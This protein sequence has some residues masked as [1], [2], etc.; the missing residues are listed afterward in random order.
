MVFADVLQDISTKKYHDNRSE[1]RKNIM[2][3]V[4]NTGTEIIDTFCQPDFII[5]LLLLEILKVDI[6]QNT[7]F[8]YGWFFVR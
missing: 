7:N 3:H 5:S 6:D 8:H 1:K 2:F 4:T